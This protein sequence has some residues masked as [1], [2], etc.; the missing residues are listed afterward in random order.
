MIY[1]LS[2]GRKFVSDRLSSSVERGSHIFK[3]DLNTKFYYSTRIYS[4]PVGDHELLFAPDF[5]GAPFLVSKAIFRLT[6]QFTSGA[7]V[8]EVLS[9]N[10]SADLEFGKL[11]D[12]LAFLEGRGILKSE[13]T[14]SRYSATALD[15]S[16]AREISIW[17]H[18]N[19]HCNLDCGY[20]FVKKFQSA[21]DDQ[22]FAEFADNLE[23]TVVARKLT[24]VT[25]KFAGGEPTLDLKRLIAFHHEL[26]SRMASHGVRYRSAILSNGT[27]V[28]PRLIDFLK[29]EDVSISI[30]LDG[31]GEEGHDI[32]RVFQNSRKGS[33]NRIHA[34]FDKLLSENIRPYVTATISAKSSATLPDLVEWIFSNGMRTRL[35]VVREPEETWT[36]REGMAAAYRRLTDTM[37]E[38][39]EKAFEVL[40]SEA[41]P[42]NPVRDLTICELRFAS[43]SFSAPCGIGSSHVVVQDDGRIASCPMTIREGSAQ[44]TGTDLLSVMANTFPLDADRRNNREGNCLDC[45]W[46]PVC[47]GGCP[48]NNERANGDPYTISPLHDFYQYVIPRFL[49]ICGLKLHQEAHRRN[50]L[51]FDLIDVF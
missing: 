10:M 8:G 35:G 51:E 25:V 24:G 6:T 38:N 19:N 11:L 40:E 33:W 12:I 17:F 23:M 49:D 36:D 18:I 26:K 29:E 22:T 9:S 13:P 34:N 21:M 44:D 16:P 39:F 28:T 5:Y 14:P 47:V 2:G 41:Y 37:S 50:M 7:T 4:R 48:V 45:Q 43:P 31:F 32:Y 27:A 46:F 3:Y 30:S 15:Q 1:G 20:C 42:M